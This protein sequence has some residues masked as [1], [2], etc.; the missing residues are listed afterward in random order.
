MEVET[1]TQG[2]DSGGPDGR[3]GSKDN[4]GEQNVKA[5]TSKAGM[6]AQTAA[7][8]LWDLDEREAW[9]DQD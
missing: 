9:G 2:D 6:K 8:V 4:N 5:K 1:L 7:G 3:I